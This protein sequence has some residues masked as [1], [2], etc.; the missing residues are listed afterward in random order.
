M[1]WYVAGEAELGN[2][3]VA[4]GWRRRGVGRRMLDWALARA[5]ERGARRIFL[6]V[7]LSNRA[8]QA[9]YERRGFVQ[10][11]LRRRYYRAPTEDARVLC[12]D[13]GPSS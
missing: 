7:R 1:V 9:L 8:A 6:E 13:L 12:L 11:G 3:A 5:R 2:L 4:R 10:V